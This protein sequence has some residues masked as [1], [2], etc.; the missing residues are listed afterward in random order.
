M[1]Q[2]CTLNDDYASFRKKI[3]KLYSQYLVYILVY[4]IDTIS[5]IPKS[6]PY[7]FILQKGSDSEGI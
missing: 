1:C 2:T 3:K 4:A 5:I 6:M 7:L